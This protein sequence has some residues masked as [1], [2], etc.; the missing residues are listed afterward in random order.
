MTEEVLV[1]IVSVIVAAA[2]VT[3]GGAAI[4]GAGDVAWKASG[5]F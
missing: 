2:L 1:F 3:L 5:P 4:V